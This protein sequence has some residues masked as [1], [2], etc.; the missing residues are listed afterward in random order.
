MVGNMQSFWAGFEKRAEDTAV[1][2]VLHTAKH[3]AGGAA[4]G[5]LT[6]AGAGALTKDW[7]TAT[8]LGLGGA[9]LGALGGTISAGKTLTPKE[10]RERQNAQRE[11]GERVTGNEELVRYLKKVIGATAL[12]TAG[13]AAAGHALRHGAPKRFDRYTPFNYA[14]NGALIGAL[15]AMAR[16]AI[17][18]KSDEKRDA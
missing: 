18:Q 10:L 15:G 9:G 7:I 13:G 4:L 1:N 17:T 12:G 2:K 6:G 8:I 16:E 3:V 5:G 14:A 11:R